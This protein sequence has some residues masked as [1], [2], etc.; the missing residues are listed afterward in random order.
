MFCLRSDFTFGG[1]RISQAFGMSM[2]LACPGCGFRTIGEDFYGTYEICPICGWEDDAVQLANPCSRGG[3]NK[4]SLAEYQNGSAAW[5]KEQI[6]KYEQDTEWRPLTEVEIA[7]FTS[8]AKREH[9]AF[10]GDT[11]PKLAYWR[12]AKAKS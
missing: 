11:D 9:W 6:E 12:K 3:A 7:Y 5:P 2:S 10:Q 8:V 1:G 4:E